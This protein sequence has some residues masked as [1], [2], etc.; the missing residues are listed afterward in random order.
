M[1]QERNKASYLPSL[2]E[3]TRKAHI[4]AEKRLLYFD[5]LTKHA[6]VY[7]ACLTVLFS[8]LSFCFPHHQLVAF[9]AI[10]MAVTLTVVAVF[11]SMQDFGS[12]A[13]EMRYSYISL[14]KLWFELDGELKNETAEERA[15][16]I[17][18]EYVHLLER[19][20]N[21]TDEDYEHAL[22]V[23]A[24]ILDGKP[25]SEKKSKEKQKWP[26]RKY[27]VAVYIFPGLLIVCLTVLYLGVKNACL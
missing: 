12:R 23:K 3:K 21:H 4:Q 22:E 19:T 16:R 9:L 6:N 11:A 27:K 2:I 25:V 15:D 7:Y 20:E 26:S 10:G 18:I 14:Q 13:I 8:L 5:Q 17:G 24:A 1:P